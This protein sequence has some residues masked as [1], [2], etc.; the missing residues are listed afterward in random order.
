[1]PEAAVAPAPQPVTVVVADQ[2]KLDTAA[3]DAADAKAWENITGAEPDGN[4][5]PAPPDFA[6]L[7]AEGKT[8]DAGRGPDGKFVKGGKTAAEESTALG[9]KK[10]KETDSRESADDESVAPQKPSDKKK[11][12]KPPLD[13]DQRR[14]ILA[15]K[16]VVGRVLKWSEEKIEASDPEFITDLAQSLKPVF[17]TVEALKTD[18]QKWKDRARGQKPADTD[19]PDNG[20]GRTAEPVDKAEPQPAERDTEGGSDQLLRDYLDPETFSQ[21]KK[22]Q[23]AE[24]ARFQDQATKAEQRAEAAEAQLRSAESL[25]M[26]D[27]LDAARERVAEEFP[28]LKDDERYF[29]VVKVM[30]QM[31]PDEFHSRDS[32][33]EFT[34]FMRKVARSEFYEDM[35]RTTRQRLITG[36]RKDANNQPETTSHGSQPVAMSWDDYENYAAWAAIEAGGNSA[37]MQG[38]MARVKRP[39]RP[40]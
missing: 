2:A 34:K 18:L 12:D 32:L 39:A 16:E 9:D 28:Q 10:P 13:R 35:E 21:V 6:K 25:F 36:N 17:G 5:I 31:D 33:A 8:T 20:R 26:K 7:E 14:K 19:T 23:R 29:E 1:M 38:L 15:A 4:D 3:R 27:R 11:D 37:K 24:R 30:D 40:K 22:S